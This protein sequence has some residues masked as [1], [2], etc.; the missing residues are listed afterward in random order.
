MKIN[1]KEK[2]VARW[3]LNKK[4]NENSIAHEC[5]GTEKCSEMVMVMKIVE[6]Y[7]NVNF[8]IP[9]SPSLFLNQKKRYCDVLGLEHSS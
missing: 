1:R 2:S 5:N 8:S 3:L 7:K 4:E 6:I 9:F